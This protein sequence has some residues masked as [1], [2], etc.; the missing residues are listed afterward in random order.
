MFVVAREH[1]RGW[2]YGGRPG[3]CWTV[4]RPGLP[5]EIGQPETIGWL[6]RLVL[7]T[8]RELREV[9]PGKS[10]IAVFLP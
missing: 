8:P 3:V 7:D 10:A 6:D 5:S 2:E 9:G 4:P 1:F